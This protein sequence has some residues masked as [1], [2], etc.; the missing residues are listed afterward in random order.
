MYILQST[1][2]E[3]A[4]NPLL[5][6]GLL[7]FS[8]LFFIVGVISVPL[9]VCKIPEDYFLRGKRSWSSS[10][11]Q[12]GLAFILILLLKNCLAVV[13][14]IAGLLMLFLPGQGLLS[15]F[16]GILLLDFPGKYLLERWLIRK[17]AL[18]KSLNWIRGKKGVA[19]I[20]IP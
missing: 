5:L 8:I 17:P 4:S 6:K 1:L 13:L 18:H 12:F 2:N 15:L 14:F 19:E 7:I 3:L 10:Y 9:L 20:L 16:L 11:K